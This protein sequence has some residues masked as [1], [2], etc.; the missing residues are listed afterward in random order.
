MRQSTALLPVLL[1]VILGAACGSE[2]PATTGTAGGGGG[3]R[4][5]GGGTTGGSGGTTAGT[6]GATAGS[7]G[8]TAGSGGSGGATAG[9]GGGSAGNAGGRG[10]AGGASGGA[11]GASGGSAGTGGAGGTSAPACPAAPPQSGSNCAPGLSCYYEDCAGA[12]RTVATCVA[13]SVSSPRWQVTTSAC[14]AVTCPNPASSTMCAAGQVCVVRV[15]G[16]LFADCV[17][18]SC[19]T[20]AISCG[21]LQSCSGTCT[22]IGSAQGGVSV[23]CNTCPAG[24]ACP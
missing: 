21:C 6:G 17:C 15:G 23:L 2:S 8:A 1:V 18:N 13:G 19:G 20:S 4:G 16:A 10:G 22:V 9:A 11:G 24:L 5:G 3:G 12:G 7:G 14:T